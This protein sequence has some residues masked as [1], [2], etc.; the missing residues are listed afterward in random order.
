MA[1]NHTITMETYFETHYVGKEQCFEGCEALS[2]VKLGR[3][4]DLWALW[5]LET[6][7]PLVHSILASLGMLQPRAFGSLNSAIEP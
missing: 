4:Q 1:L 3:Y 7:R 5:Q 2:K 6:L